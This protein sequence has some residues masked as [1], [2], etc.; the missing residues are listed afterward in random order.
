MRVVEGKC[1][2]LFQRTY[3]VAAFDGTST[4]L[5]A[6]RHFLHEHSPGKWIGLSVLN[7]W[8][9]MSPDLTHLNFSLCGIVKEAMCVF[10]VLNG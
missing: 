5:L 7:P 9:P 2:G 3:F 8:P 4:F 10:P 1:R 6:V